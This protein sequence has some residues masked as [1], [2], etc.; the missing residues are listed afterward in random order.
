MTI[1]F[2]SL[3]LYCRTWKTWSVY[4]CYEGL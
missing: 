2:F 3:I 4:L 1:V